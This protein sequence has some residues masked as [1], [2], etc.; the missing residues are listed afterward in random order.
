MG[1]RGWEQ[2]TSLK[3]GACP[4][5]PRMRRCT[6]LLAALTMKSATSRPGS[7]EALGHEATF[8]RKRSGDVQRGEL[9]ENS[10]G[11]LDQRAAETF[12]DDPYSLGAKD[13]SDSLRFPVVSE[14]EG[15]KSHFRKD[16]DRDY[17]DNRFLYYIQYRPIYYFLSSWL[18]R[19]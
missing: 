11:R 4:G 17:I 10:R 12:D 3:S 14:Y 13:G 15:D 9:V 19:N 16:R 2:N 18:P 8:D 7:F 5:V 1:L 6:S